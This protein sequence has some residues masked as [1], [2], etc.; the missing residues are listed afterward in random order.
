MRRLAAALELAPAAQA[1]LAGAARPSAA[2][3]GGPAAPRHNLPLQLTSFVGREREL[4]AVRE[5]LAAHRL[6]ALTGPGG[7]GKTRLAFE[8][9]GRALEAYPHGAPYPA[10]VWFVDLA[11]LGDGALVPRA[12]LASLGVR[13]RSG[14]APLATLTEYLGGRTLLLV[15]DNCEHLLDACAGLVEALLRA[16]PSLRVLV[17]SREPLG[18]PGEAPYRVP[19]LD[20]PAPGA[21]PTAGAVTRYSAVRLFAE[22][23]ALVRPGFAVTDRTAPPRRSRRCAGGW[24]ASP[25][26]SSSP[27]RRCVCSRSRRSPPACPTGSAC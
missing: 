11:P 26:P 27:P 12:V 10:G 5:A 15:L 9:A 16:C 1:A 19:P 24:T 25:W 3:P 2:R 4:A 18:V 14:Q 21:P 7:S 22:R 20:V 6:V 17:T 13:A 8:V 23:A